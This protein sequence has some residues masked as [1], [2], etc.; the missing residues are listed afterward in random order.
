[1][2]EP[3][4]KLRRNML[5]R[6]LLMAFCS[7]VYCGRILVGCNYLDENKVMPCFQC[8]R[9]WKCKLKHLYPFK[10][11]MDG[12]LGD[13]YSKVN[14]RYDYVVVNRPCQDCGSFINAQQ[15]EE[16]FAAVQVAQP[17]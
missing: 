2:V 15:L 3:T 1:M 14:L 5:R 17:S 10:E 7:E 13:I 9:S 16:Q 12:V 8:E 11:I 4:V 6:P